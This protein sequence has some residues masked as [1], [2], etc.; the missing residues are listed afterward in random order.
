MNI[1]PLAIIHP[2]AQLGVNIRIDPFATVDADV[3]I[4]D[5]TWIRSHAHINDGTTIGSDCIIY[6]GAIIGGDSQDKKYIGGNTRLIVGNQVTIRE[7]CTLNRSTSEVGITRIADKCLLMAYVHIAH[8][9]Q[10]GANSI[11]ANAVNL[12][13]HVVLDEYATIGGMTAIQQYVRIGKHAYVGGGTLIRKDV[14]PYVRAAREPVAYMGINKV[15]LERRGFSQDK[16]KS[17]QDL[18]RY[19]FVH[20]NNV[21]QSMLLLQNRFKGNPFREEIMNFIIESPNGVIR[22]Y[23]SEE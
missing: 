11:I 21:S 2:Q 10:I 16:I 12:A 14:P 9:C 18:Y 1:S 3:V 22:G 13:G 23:R 7:Y 6:Q 20:S 15:G 8:D 19:I 17:L 5:R 4:G